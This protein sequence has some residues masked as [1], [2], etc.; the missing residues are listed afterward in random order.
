MDAGGL[1]CWFWWCVVWQWSAIDEQ[2]YFTPLSMNSGMLNSDALQGAL[3]QRRRDDERGQ[4][5]IDILCFA[6]LSGLQMCCACVQ[7]TGAEC[8]IGGDEDSAS[9]VGN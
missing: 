6:L 7:W 4:I 9:W 5:R 3:Q 2:C 8:S 1:L